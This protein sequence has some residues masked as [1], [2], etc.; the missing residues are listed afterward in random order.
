MAAEQQQGGTSKAPPQSQ[1]QPNAKDARYTPAPGAGTPK[2]HNG[3]PYQ[4]RPASFSQMATSAGPSTLAKINTVSYR[5]ATI[6]AQIDT[7]MVV[8]DVI[9]QLCANAHLGVQEPPALFA[10]RDE[11]NDELIDDANL[12]KK[13]EA[14]TSFKLTASPL[15]EAAEMVDKLSSR[16]ERTLKMATYTLQRLIREPA[17][18]AEFIRRGGVTELIGL[19]Q[20]FSSGN[21]LAYALTSCQNLVESSDQ[22]WDAL[23][24]DFVTKVV[25]LLVSQE[26]IN[27]CRPATAILK[28]LVVSGPATESL[29]K[30]SDGPT[31]QFGFEVVYDKIRSEPGFLPTLVH[32]LSSADATLC[33]YSLSL[34]NSL[35]RHVTTGIF[36]E[37]T[38]ELEKLGTSKAVARLMESNRGEELATSILEYQNNVVKV[39]HRRM[40]TPVTPTDKRHVQALTYIWRQAKI[41]DETATSA[42]MSHSSSTD[43][44]LGGDAATST[45]T[46]AASST[47]SRRIKWQ[48]LGFTNENVAKDFAS[49]GWL[50]L[51]CCEAFIRADPEAYSQMIL[52]QLGRPEPKR[53]PWARVSLEVVE[54]LADYWGIMT[55][56]Y[57]AT[58]FMPFLLFFSRV[59]HLAVRFFFRMWA[60]SGAAT[61]DF[62]KVAA[63]VRSQ[64][65]EGLSDEGNKGW[66]DLERVFLESEYRSVRERQMKELESEDD[67]AS[68]PAVRSLRARLY[69]ESF[70]FVRQQRLRCLLDGAWFRVALATRLASTAASQGGRARSGTVSSATGPAAAAQALSAKPWRFYRLSPNRRFLHYCEA[71]DPSA[72][73]VRSG[74]DDLPERIDLAQVTDIA[75]QSATA[76]VGLGTDL[77]GSTDLNKQSFSLLLSSDSSLA[78]LVAMSPAQY[79]EWVDG[80]SM[81]QGEGANV[82][83]AQTADYIQTLSDIALKVKL[84]DLTG[85]K[86]DVPATV[87]A[88]GL[89]SSLDFFFAEL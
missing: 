19:V 53:C 32:R 30:S 39:L 65:N 24:G 78:D 70:E 36:D 58:Q 72:V 57:T 63:L 81:L 26:R 12:A 25:R 34:L 27:V 29:S 49:T 18:T 67:L 68:K 3:L 59:H 40:Q 2:G 51:E 52:E 22:G 56:Y 60:D 79:S 37:F 47:P 46:T 44:Q 71:A 8:S 20:S 61:S 54:M 89:P 84:L 4:T 23:S 21:T 66:L 82:H 55:G 83:T 7:T 80:L 5:N 42:G 33:L 14:G 69:R 13:I 74:L 48:K 77:T 1:Q 38:N 86:I 75:I 6:K 85:E 87:P 88:P 11:E 31:S 62:P 15:I 45:A 43:S 10:L 9:R 28:K 41:P 35:M 64:I 73:H 17:F 16:E 50:G 76:V